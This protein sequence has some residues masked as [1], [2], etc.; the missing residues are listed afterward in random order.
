M[1]TNP[2]DPTAT[3]LFPNDPQATD[4]ASLAFRTDNVKNAF[5][6]LAIWLK[7]SLGGGVLKIQTLK[8]GVVI[9]SDVE[10]DWTD[11]QDA[12]VSSDE[13]LVEYVNCWCRLNL[14]GATGATLQAHLRRNDN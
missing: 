3:Q 13:I 11:T 14:T 2:I 4:S 8:P 5:N 9:G 6:R 12:I 1:A 7:G 10:G